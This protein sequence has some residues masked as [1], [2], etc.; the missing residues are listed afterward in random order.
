MLVT[1]Y[2][3]VRA[4]VYMPYLD[5]WGWLRR[6]YSD[7]DSLATLAFT[8]INGHILAVPALLYTADIVLA[9]ASN[10]INLTGLVG[11]VIGTCLLMRAGFRLPASMYWLKRWQRARQRIAAL[12][13]TKDY[14]TT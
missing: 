6:Y 14:R 13:P 1:I 3:I 11:C 2:I 4:A 7:S 12:L 10:M 8:P 5:Q 9:H